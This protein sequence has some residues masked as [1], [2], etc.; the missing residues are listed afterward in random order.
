MLGS[1]LPSPQPRAQRSATSPQSDIPARLNAA[2]FR[3]R[4]PGRAAKRILAIRYARSPLRPVPC[5]PVPRCPLPV[6]CCLFPVASLP[7]P[8]CLLPVACCLLPVA[9]FLPN[10]PKKRPW[11]YRKRS[12]CKENEANRTEAKPI[13]NPGPGG[14]WRVGASVP[15]GTT[16]DLRGAFVGPGRTRG[17]RWPRWVGCRGHHSRGDRGRR[18]VVGPGGRGAFL[19]GGVRWP[20]RGRSRRRGRLRCRFRRGSRGW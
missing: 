15:D 3:P 5:C 10:E 16:R 1:W 8:G 6:P 13:R 18:Q 12:L 17:G 4:R 2:P 7:V 19:V 20:V 9:F 14:R 11:R